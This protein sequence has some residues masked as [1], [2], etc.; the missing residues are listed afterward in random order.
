[1]VLIA[2]GID[3]HSICRFV[4]HLGRI[5]SLPPRPPDK[6]HP[7]GHGKAEPIAAVIVACGV[8]AAAT[9]L[10]IKACVKF[11]LHTRPGAIHLAILMFV[12]FVKE[13]LFATFNRIGIMSKVRLCKPMPG[14]IAA[15]RL[16]SAAA[17]IG[18]SIALS[19]RRMAE[20]R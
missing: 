8:L 2:D 11:L 1:M 5:E 7:Y 3:R 12:I 6:T 18:I 4:C 9:G 19:R 17:F 14:T 16:T 13:I 15:M 10:A 20:R